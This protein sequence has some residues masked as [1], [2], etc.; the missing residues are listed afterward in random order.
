M[1]NQRLNYIDRLKGFAIFMVVFGHVVVYGLH[2]YDDTLR[3]FASSFHMPLFMFLSG[4]VISSVPTPQK[5]LAKACRFLCPLLTIGLLYNAYIGRL[6][7]E[8]FFDKAKSGFWYL[9]VLTEFYAILMLLRNNHKNTKKIGKT[10]D[11]LFLVIILV[12]FAFL[13]SKNPRISNFLSLGSCKNY[14][15]FFYGGYLCHKYNLIAFIEKHARLVYAAGTILFISVFSMA[16]AHNL[17][18]VVNAV[19]G[20]AAIPF[21]IL[22]F[23]EREDKHNFWDQELQ[24]L[25]QNSFEIYMFEYFF[26]A[27]INL[28]GLE[29]WFIQTHNQ[30]LQI[31]FTLVM[32]VAITY[33][34][35]LLGKL[36]HKTGYL[37]DIIYGKFAQKLL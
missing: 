22:L 13:E 37:D 16:V 14:W 33:S 35:L 30:F 3:M 20:I 15:P 32:A 25:G 21:L 2:N 34:S 11:T 19:T 29:N 27:N 7:L 24:R 9:W 23:K 31:I 36:S 26:L 12:T 17:T 1:Q 4:L 18:S 28:H 6:P 5:F 10:I 8:M